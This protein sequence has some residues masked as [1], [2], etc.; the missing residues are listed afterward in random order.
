T[1][2]NSCP[3]PSSVQRCSWDARLRTPPHLRRSLPAN[4]ASCPRRLEVLL[5]TAGAWSISVRTATNSFG[6]SKALTAT[7]KTFPPAGN[8]NTISSFGRDG[9]HLPHGDMQQHPSA[10]DCL[11][12]G[13]AA[14]G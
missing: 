5:M 3:E 12:V 8:G 2:R 4:T 13:V 1:G 9:P 14:G 11:R 7:P 6:R 10:D